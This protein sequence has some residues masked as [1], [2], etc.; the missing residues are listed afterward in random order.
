M[1]SDTPSQAERAGAALN[2]L[3][4]DA[5]GNHQR[6]LDADGCEVGV[7]RQALDELLAAYKAAV[8]RV[9][10][11]TDAE[12]GGIHRSFAPASPPAEALPSQSGAEAGGEATKDIVE[13]LSYE[14][15][16]LHAG[17][18][19]YRVVEEALAEIIRHRALAKPASEP[20]GGGVTIKSLEW[21]PCAITKMSGLIV[22]HGLL[23]VASAA[24]AC[25]LYGIC[26]GSQ[27]RYE[28]W[29]GHHMVTGSYDTLEQARAKAEVHYEARILGALSSPA[30]SSPAEAE[31][32]QAGG[33]ADH[34]QQLCAALQID[35][36]SNLAPDR[37][38]AHARH[39]AR[40]LDR[41]LSSASA[42]GNGSK[43]LS[44]HPRGSGQSA[45]SVEGRE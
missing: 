35:H 3:A 15:H 8:D 13:K 18:R 4:L 12:T 33:E 44:A 38:I 43:D 41:F 25:G 9:N 16:C 6:Q 14:L 40:E 1:T 23:I 22:A 34:W 24:S 30:S 45:G 26:K 5:L 42:Q 7:S 28:V 11:A 19:Q 10:R 32:L 36:W 39:V 2:P 20:A 27:G 37:V 31:A 21:K 29:L 17:G